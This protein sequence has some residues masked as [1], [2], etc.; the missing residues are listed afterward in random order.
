MAD[1]DVSLGGLGPGYIAQDV[2]REPLDQI[3]LKDGVDANLGGG[4]GNFCKLIVTPQNFQFW[5]VHRKY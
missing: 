1:V 3:D 2:Q 5:V 4:G